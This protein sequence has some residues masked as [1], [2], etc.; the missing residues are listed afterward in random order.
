M[1]RKK[2]ELWRGSQVLDDVNWDCR[3]G[4]SSLRRWSLARNPKRQSGWPLGYLREGCVTEPG[5]WLR[6]LE[7]IRNLEANG[8]QGRPEG[9]TRWP[10]IQQKSETLGDFTECCG[11]FL[12]VLSALESFLWMANV[13]LQGINIFCHNYWPLHLQDKVSH[14]Q[15]IGGWTWLH[16]DTNLLC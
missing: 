4:G 5:N 12:T 6:V 3:L 15:H 7:E 11:F 13:S 16:C 10:E 8:W 2:D 9:N 14:R 1:L